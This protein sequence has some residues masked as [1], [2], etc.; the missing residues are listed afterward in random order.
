WLAFLNNEQEF[1]ERLPYAYAPEVVPGNKLAPKLARRGIQLERVPLSDVTFAYF[2]MTDPVVGGYTP[3]QEALR[4]AIGLAYAAQAELR[5]PRRGQP[6]VAQ[7]PVMPLTAI[8]DPDFR[9]E[10]GTF[11]P[12]RAMALLDMYGYKDRDG[13]G[14]RELPDGSPLSIDYYTL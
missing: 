7:G 10:M 8:Y 6:I 2:N 11:D 3:R 13:D 5:L 9:S 1:I 4:R 12:A 14:W